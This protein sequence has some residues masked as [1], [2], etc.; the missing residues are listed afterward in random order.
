M[1]QEFLRDVLRTGDDAG[2][3]R[4]RWS[5]VPV[6]IVGHALLLVALVII[7]LGADVA[8]PDIASPIKLAQFMR[9]VSPPAPPPP[10]SAVAPAPTRPLAPIEAPSDFAPER[11]DAPANPVDGAIPL[12]VGV[13]S[14]EPGLVNVG[15]TPPPPLPP[16]PPPQPRIVRAGH[17]VREPKKIVNVPPEYPELAKRAG[18]EGVVILEAV[19][20][21]SGHVDHVKVLSSIPMLNEA[22]IRAVKQWRYTPT[23]LNGVPIPVLLTITVRFSIVR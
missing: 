12:G 23:E 13:A 4:R 3:S 5:M 19:I 1:P 17:G 2:R 18:I 16:P 9:T 14:G 20:D 8:M 7:P 11:P 10:P 21:V 6:S 22:A 15:V